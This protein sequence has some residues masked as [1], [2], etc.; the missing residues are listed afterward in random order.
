[1]LDNSFPS[2]YMVP[3]VFCE[4][5]ELVL[6]HGVFGVIVAEMI[7]GTRGV[8]D[9]LARR[10]VAVVGGEGGGVA[11]EE[12]GDGGGAVA[13]AG[14]AFDPEEV[15]AGVGDEEEALG[16]GAEAEVGEVLA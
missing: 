2:G 11:G 8:G 9:E 15:A 13:A 16:R 5:T 7:F 6:C 12:G 1:M 3:T 10:V 4:F 14:G